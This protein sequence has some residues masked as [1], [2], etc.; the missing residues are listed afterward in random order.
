MMASVDGRIAVTGWP[1][2]DELRAEYESIHDSYGADGWI[3]GRVTMEPFAKHTRSEAEIASEQPGSGGRDDY[4]APGSYESFAFALD[5]S[6]RLAWDSNDI[7]GDHVVSILS[8]R[9][10]D[11]YLAFLRD[12]RVSY[13][14]AGETDID[15]AIALNKIGKIFG[16]KTLMLEGGGK[17]NGGVLRAGLIDELSLLIAP[18]ADGRVGLPSL[19]DIVDTDASPVQ[20]RLEHVDQRAANIVWLRY[21]ISV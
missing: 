12:R 1:I 10:S 9:V 19:F 16:V 15:L 11:K 3:C 18:V 20:L 7:G 14:L 17:I 2:P 5:A 8:N 13:I 21:R 4:I 6:G